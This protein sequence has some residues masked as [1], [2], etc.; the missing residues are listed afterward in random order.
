MVGESD[1]D[2]DQSNERWLKTAPLD[3]VMILPYVK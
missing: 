3:H 2:T 1:E